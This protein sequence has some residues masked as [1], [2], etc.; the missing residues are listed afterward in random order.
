MW[1]IVSSQRAREYLVTPL[2]WER[3]EGEGD[4]VVTPNLES[5][6][7]IFSTDD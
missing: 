6:I 7:L 5:T 3:G 1:V 2:Q 4:L